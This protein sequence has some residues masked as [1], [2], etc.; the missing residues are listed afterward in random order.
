MVPLWGCLLAVVA[1]DFVAVPQLEPDLVVQI[2]LV[3]LLPW[4]EDQATL[5]HEKESLPLLSYLNL[6][7]LPIGINLTCLGALPGVFFLFGFLEESVTLLVCE[8]LDLG[9]PTFGFPSGTHGVWCTDFVLGLPTLDVEVEGLS[10][11]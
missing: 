9:L 10:A 5:T 6:F 11:L 3:A 2:N 8:D 7:L 4:E 1:P